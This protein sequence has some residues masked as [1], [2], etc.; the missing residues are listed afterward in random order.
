MERT[1]HNPW[2]IAQDIRNK[3]LLTKKF[4]IFDGSQE[5]LFWLGC[6]LSYDPHGQAVAAAMK[7]ILDTAGISW[8]VLP[9]EYRCGDPARRA[10]HEYPYSQLAEQ[11]IGIFEEK[12]VKKIVSCCP[13]CTTM[14]DKDYRQIPSFAALG[15]QV[16]HHSEFISD[17]LP[18]LNLRPSL[19]K[20]SYHDPCYLARALG[21]TTQ[22]RN[23][24]KACGVSILEPAKH[25]QNTSCCG[26]GG[27]QIFIVDDLKNKDS[28]RINYGR[29]DEIVKTGT[30]AIAV[31]CPYCPIM[32]QDAANHSGCETDILDI[33]EITAMH[34]EK[35]E[36][37]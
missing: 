14:L 31:A 5:W 4:P 15:I 12:G 29:F 8:G 19:R 7:Q 32:L 37:G 10:G 1:P 33:A 18:S 30:S 11:I 3:L 34:L 26:A 28:K 27:A 25:G 17:L 2:G 35:K 23:I 13:H 16:K 9:K 20:M 22:P 21:I 6:G 24:L 36:G